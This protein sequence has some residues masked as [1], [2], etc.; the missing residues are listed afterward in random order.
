[1]LSELKNVQRRGTEAKAECPFKSLHEE[2]VDTNP[3]LTVNLSRGLYYCQTC[4]SKGNVHTLY[5]TVYNVSNEQAWFELGDALKIERPDSTKPTRPSIEIGLVSEYNKALMKLTGPIRQVLQERR[6][7][8]NDT[9]KRFQLGWDGD[10]LTIPI[11]SEFNELVNFRRYK[12][13]SDEDQWKVLN[14]VD[15]A[16]NAYGEVRIYGID[17]LVDKS[18]E[19]VIWCEGELDRIC[20]EQHG[21][22]SACATSG[23]GAWK[24][25]WVNY[26]RN[27]KKIYIV[28]DND[29]AGNIATKKLCEKLCR[30]VS[31]YT[32]QWPEDFPV[33]GD[34]TDFFTKC[35]L[36]REDFKKLL[37][38]ATRYIDPSNSASL[39][40]ENEAIE[41]HLA[42]SSNAELYGKRIRV[43]VMV[44]GKDQTPY[45]CPRK[46]RAYCGDSADSDNKACEMCSLV[47][48]AGEIIRELHSVDKD[49]MKLIK[50]TES[51]QQAVIKEM[52]GINKKCYKCVINAQEFMNI[53]ELRLIP[54]AE[55]NFGFSKSH[56]Y[57]TRNCY[58]IGSDIASN[59]RYT[60]VGYMYPEPQTQYATTV[61]DK[62]YPDKDIISEF[63]VTE[64][65]IEQLSIFKVVDNQTVNEKFNDIHSDL[66][67]NIT[68]IWER[69]NVAIAVDIIYHTVLSFYF[70]EQVV[71]RGW[72][73]LLIIGDS[74]QAK[75]TLVEKMMSHYK[76]GELHS[77]ESS[78]RTG[79]VYNIQQT[80]KKW[81]LV[82]GAFPLNDGGLITIDELS[83]IKEDELS[84][85]SDVRSSGIAKATGVITSETTARTRAIYI[86]NPR[87]GKQLNAETY[88]VNAVLKL[89]GKAEDVRRLDLAV[90]VASGDVDPILVNRSID[91]VPSVVHKYTSELCNLRVLWAWSR[92]T[93]DIVF[94]EDAVKAILSYA[95]I[96]GTKYSSKVPL[97]EASDQRLKIARL[98]I[99]VACSVFSTTNGKDVVVKKEH[100]DFIVNFMET[101]YS[102]AG[103]G[104]DK[105]SK[106]D[107]TVN[108]TS[109]ENIQKL[110]KNF[111]LIAVPDH[112]A[113]AG[114]LYQI[115][116]FSR[117]TLMDYTGLP[118]DELSMLL[119]FLTNLSLVEGF[120]NDYRRL[121]LG[122][123]FL[124]DVIA[125]PITTKEVL[126]SR[127]Q[128]SN[129]NEF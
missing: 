100:V 11:Y 126:L 88:G 25:E 67:R 62:A 50:C 77:G 9:L 128:V 109:E 54:K 124:E 115:P 26:F 33:K 21:F 97:V 53:E 12:W 22:P 103:L 114:V 99:G 2:G 7:L 110:R 27:K 70:Q 32:I 19:E 90:A 93:D 82:W 31:V 39:A 13:N 52:L 81:F 104:Y 65:V 56:E 66:E 74:G 36:D 116:Y 79:L 108:D 64:D 121:P 46:I 78:K 8:S 14:Y 40:D 34:I 96:M 107:R 105:L 84:V 16:S 28:Q 35:K 85:M 98:S 102:S 1:M 120:K 59:K 57:V 37:S 91:E 87:N 51:A 20:A 117:S 80:G 127:K 3:S 6:G 73:E 113:L 43:P 48:N 94:E 125:N 122:T 106:L 111:M 129:N 63:E 71:K 89:F 69:R 75:T 10:R 55:A 47:T 41:V 86:S 38:E 30:V 4:H 76:L 101:V 60:L 58:Y 112:T 18:I 23:A 44:S 92:K 24:P 83:G 118:Q 95:T 49:V 123:K 61:F 72:G 119:K 5:K 17:N 68:H 45:V 42:D 29:T 15:E